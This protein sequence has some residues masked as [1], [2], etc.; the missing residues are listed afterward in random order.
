MVPI[1]FGLNPDFVD[2]HSPLN[3]KSSHDCPI[4]FRWGSSSMNFVWIQPLVCCPHWLGSAINW[5]ALLLQISKGPLLR[6]QAISEH[7]AVIPTLSQR[8]WSSSCP[9]RSQ[10]ISLA[11]P[12]SIVPT[13]RQTIT[14]HGP[15][16]CTKRN[17]KVPQRWC[18]SRATTGKLPRILHKMQRPLNGR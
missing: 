2:L 3:Q 17:P 5:G 11:L 8:D 15:F 14:Q 13:R 18:L 16:F 1:H 12:T 10:N 9:P 6:W 7:T 4:G